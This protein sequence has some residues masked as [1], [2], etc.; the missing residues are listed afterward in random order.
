MFRARFLAQLQYRAAALA[1]F[2]TQVFFGFVRIM[3]F[4][5]FFRSA[6]GPHPMTYEEVVTYVWLGQATLMLLLWRPDPDIEGLFRTGHVAYEMLRP[7]DL[8]GLWFARAIANRAAPT[9][10]RAIPML[11]LAFLFFGLKLPPSWASFGAWIVATAGAL[12]LSGSIGVLLMVSLFWTV[13]G[14]GIVILVNT[15]VWALSGIIL[16]LPLLPDWVRPIVAFLP[17][18]GLMDTPFRLWIGH[19]PPHEVVGALAHQLLWVVAFIALGRWLLARGRRRLVV[20]G[21]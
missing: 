16:P 7:V 2:G 3:I 6:A 11:L 13:S 12:V 1:G 8:Y 15:G 9:L 19:M 21:G 14:R 10:I 5:A 4:A 18:R 17:F 20:Q